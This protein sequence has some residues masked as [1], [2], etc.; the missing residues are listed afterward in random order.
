MHLDDFIRRGVVGDVPKAGRKAVSAV[1]YL[2]AGVVIIAITI[3]G[4][5]YDISRIGLMG[6]LFAM[7]VCTLPEI[8][9]KLD[10]T[11]SWIYDTREPVIQR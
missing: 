7:W 5:L 6:F 2:S 11:K 1:C 8:M 3:I 10:Y 9:D 4:V